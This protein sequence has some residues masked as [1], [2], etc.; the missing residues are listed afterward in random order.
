MTASYTEAG[1][2]LLYSAPNRLCVQVRGTDLPRSAWGGLFPLPEA[3]LDRSFDETVTYAAQPSGF[4]Q[5]D[6]LRIS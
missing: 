4:V 2:G 3:R 5:A 1:G 6:S